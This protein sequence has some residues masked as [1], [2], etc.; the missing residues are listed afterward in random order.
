MLDPDADG[1]ATF[2]WNRFL[3]DSFEK[4]LDIPALN[5]TSE[6]LLQHHVKRYNM[7]AVEL[8]GSPQITTHILN[9]G[10]IT[11]LCYAV[12]GTIPKFRLYQRPFFGSTGWNILDTA[13]DGLGKAFLDWRS[14]RLKTFTHS[15]QW[16]YWIWQDIGSVLGNIPVQL[17]VKYYRSDGV[18]DEF[19]FLT[20]PNVNVYDCYGFPA[21]FTQL[22]LSAY[23]TPTAKITKYETLIAVQYLGDWLELSERKIWDVNRK[24]YDTVVAMTYQN[25]LGV[26]TQ[27]N[28]HGD[29]SYQVTA[30]KKI[31]P[32]HW[33]MNSDLAQGESIAQDV[34]VSNT[35]IV[36][37]GIMTR[38]EAIQFQDIIASP[39]VL[40]QLDGQRVPVVIANAKMP[41]KVSDNVFRYTLEFSYDFNDPVA[42][43][44]I[45][46]L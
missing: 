12:K 27:F 5:G 21:G 41:V 44:F 33:D 35:G 4:N 24:H 18:C 31:T 15:E 25:S 40:L 14:N 39:K 16:I 9:Y 29:A 28:L 13:S 17:R 8:S 26:M 46:R 45:V 32:Q 38:N 23:E 19:T 20:T 6:F 7:F 36:A 11:D 10:D 1:Y 22:G 37:S 43:T 30:D 34:I 3:W 42:D 2:Y